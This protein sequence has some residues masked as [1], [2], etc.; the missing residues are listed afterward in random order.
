MIAQRSY[1]FVGCPSGDGECFCWHVEASEYKRAEGKEWHDERVE[2]R[3]ES[4]VPASAPFLL[5]PSSVLCK[6]HIRQGDKLYKFTI[7]AEEVGEV[8]KEWMEEDAL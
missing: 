3:K 7:T 4:G 1:S 8:P 6:M 2:Y 5:Y